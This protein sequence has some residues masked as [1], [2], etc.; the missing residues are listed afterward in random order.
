VRRAYHADVAHNDDKDTELPHV[1]E[2]LVVVDDEKSEDAMSSTGSTAL[3][4]STFI[5]VTP[6]IMK[7]DR[8]FESVVTP[9]HLQSVFDPPA[10]TP[11]KC[12]I[13]SSPRSMPEKPKQ[14]ASAVARED[15]ELCGQLGSGGY[16]IVELAVHKRTKQQY[17][18]KR[19][20]KEKLCEPYLQ[21]QLLTE[22]TILR[23]CTSPFVVQLHATFQ[24]AS[25]IAFLLELAPGGDLLDAMGKHELCGNAACARFFCAGIMLA[26]GHLHDRQVIFRD[27]KPENIL[28]D[29]KGWPKITD[30]GFAKICSEDT[31]TCCGTPCYMAPEMW[32]RLGHGKAVD[33]W[34]FGVLTYE[35]MSG[36]TPFE[37]SDGDEEA[38][39]QAIEEGIVCPGDWPWPAGF[40]SELRDLVSGFLKPF[41]PQ[42]LPMRA[43]GLSNIKEHLWFR[44]SEFNWEAYEARVLRPPCGIPRTWL[45]I[46][47]R[48]LPA[49]PGGWNASEVPATLGTPS[50]DPAL[51]EL[52]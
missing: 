1:S 46:E 45:P 34:S 31:F 40:T 14:Q 12:S 10:R 17:A 19:I 8:E 36:C 33:W 21:T 27:L 23:M 18:L 2:E 13:Q 51:L 35:L 41:P 43:G 49:S 52:N 15:I 44:A 25:S 32:L 24:D 16:S 50:F 11:S 20:S 3:P 22:E 9:A 48:L 29:S 37:T 38:M 47:S 7:D 5:R 39:R 6:P 30:F 28:L 26:I 4:K 42:R